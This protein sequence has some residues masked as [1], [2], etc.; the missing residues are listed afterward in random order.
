MEPSVLHPGV[1]VAERYE[2]VR[3]LGRGG[4]GEVW[5]AHHVALDV[6]CAIKFISGLADEPE[7]ADRAELRTRFQR[8][9]RMAAHVRSANVVQI[10]DYGIWQDLPYIAMELLEG[11][12][13]EARI[14]RLGRLSIDET[15]I[16][17][18][19]VARA[20]AHAHRCGIVHRD[21]KPENIF[22]V[23]QGDSVTA[24]VFDFGIA[25]GAQTVDSDGARQTKT[26]TWLGTPNYMSPEQIGGARDVDHRADLWSLAVVVFECLT[27]HMAYGGVS[28][29]T[30]FEQ[31]YYQPL[32]SPRTLVPELPPAFDAWCARAAAK[33]PEHRF[34]TSSEFTEALH[35]ALR[36]EASSAANI[37]DMFVWT[38]DSPTGVFTRP[39]GDLDPPRVG[40]YWQPWVTRG[41]KG[42]GGRQATPQA[43]TFPGAFAVAA[44]VASVFFLVLITGVL[45]LRA[46]AAGA[47]VSA[48]THAQLEPGGQVVESA[49]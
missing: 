2:L 30:L 32:P 27:G 15:L 37:P 9:A 18:S 31:I 4:M 16:I 36:G 42:A 34:Q 19:D 14:Q 39:P 17:A 24:K 43:S 3:Q 20:L 49:P 41:R 7:E 28:L 35:E 11:E 44:I 46:N 29:T 22:V 12:S 40:R 47:D 1:V 6:S 13:L 25:K 48:S 8:E 5:E 21:L 26:G 23:G 38:D 45:F 33:L 10:L